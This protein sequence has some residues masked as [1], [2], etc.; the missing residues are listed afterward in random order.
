MELKKE[1]Y[2]N[3]LEHLPTLLSYIEKFE[4]KL[5]NIIILVNRILTF[6]TVTEAYF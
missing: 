1:D 4:K 2:E 3:L 5:M 6:S